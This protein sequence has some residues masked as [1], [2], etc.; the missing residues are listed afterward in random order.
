MKSHN[1]HFVNTIEFT[2]RNHLWSN[3]GWWFLCVLTSG[4]V[5]Q[6]SNRASPAYS[7]GQ[8]VWTAPIP[9]ATEESGRSH[10][11][12]RYGSLVVGVFFYTSVSEWSHTSARYGSP[13]V[14]VFVMPL[15]VWVIT[16][17]YQVL[18]TCNRCVFYARY[19][20]P[21]IGVCLFYASQE[22]G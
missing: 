12:A 16:H 2:Q 3:S 14:G 10:T 5:V 20:S 11:S 6:H 1:N 17:L 7:G 18:V 19:W 4:E 15:C 13:V 21:V 8:E 22:S 9:S